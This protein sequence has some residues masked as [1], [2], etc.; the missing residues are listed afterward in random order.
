MPSLSKL[1]ASDRAEHDGELV[2]AI[3]FGIGERTTLQAGK[4]HDLTIK[5]SAGVDP[6][7][8]T[9]GSYQTAAGHSPPFPRESPKAIPAEMGE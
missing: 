8:D 9:T 3:L 6:V 2:L 1:V 7:G 5:S 4:R